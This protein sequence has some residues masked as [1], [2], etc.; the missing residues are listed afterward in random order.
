MNLKVGIKIILILP[1][2]SVQSLFLKSSLI[3]QI[4]LGKLLFISN[5]QEELQ[6][7]GFN[8]LCLWQEH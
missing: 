7:H 5:L 4:V 2:K 6:E 1:L 3:F 8:S